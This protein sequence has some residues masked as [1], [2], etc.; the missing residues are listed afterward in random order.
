MRKGRNSILIESRN[1]KLI[2]RFYFWYDQKRLRRDDVIRILSEEEF[3]L[4]P[5]TIRE[6]INSNSDKLKELRQKRSKV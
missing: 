2:L 3:F 1:Q 5:Y 6:I 4:Q